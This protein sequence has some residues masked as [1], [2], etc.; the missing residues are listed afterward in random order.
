MR[1]VC[2]YGSLADEFGQTF[3]LDVFS[4]GEAVRALEANFPGR[5]FKALAVGEYHILRGKDIDSAE[6]IELDL[7]S[8]GLG[9]N[10]LHIMPALAGSG[11]KGMFS[12]VL[13]VAIIGAAV[14]TAGAAAGPGMSL[15]AAMS[16][17]ALMGISYGSFATFGAAMVLNG[18]SSMLTPT[19]SLPGTGTRVA[20]DPRTSFVFPGAQNVAA[21]GVPVPV[22]Y[23]K[24]RVGSVVISSSLIVEDVA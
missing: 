19:M 22:T 14:L 8:F 21:Q 4:A 1:S 17:T 16:E 11:D 2:L 10:D 20:V 12:V 18:M 3:S 13:G 9:K 23:G 7:V 6:D 15:A 5:F 24:Y